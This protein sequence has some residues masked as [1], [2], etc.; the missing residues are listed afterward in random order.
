MIQSLF[1]ITLP[2]ATPAAPVALDAGQTAR[3][4]RRLTEAAAALQEDDAPVAL[5]SS[6]RQDARRYLAA[7]RDGSLR[8]EGFAAT[9]ACDETA[10]L[11]LQLTMNAPAVYRIAEPLVA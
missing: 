11:V 7:R 6:L 8:L 4:S 3:L 1:G 10:R 9:R 2:I 5:A